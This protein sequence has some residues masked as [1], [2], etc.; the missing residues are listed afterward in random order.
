MYKCDKFV[1]NAHTDSAYLTDVLKDYTD[2][3]CTDFAHKEMWELYGDAESIVAQCQ[4]MVLT[5]VMLLM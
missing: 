5:I 4:P 3:A 2:N 1:G